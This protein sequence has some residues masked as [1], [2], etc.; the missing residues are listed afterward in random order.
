M[1]VAY[2]WGQ[3]VYI[4]FLNFAVEQAACWSSLMQCNCSLLVRVTIVGLL[5]HRLWS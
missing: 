3:P 5:A 4:I 1:I 2:F